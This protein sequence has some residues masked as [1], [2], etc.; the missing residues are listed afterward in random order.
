[1][2]SPS[3][4]MVGHQIDSFASTSVFRP[5]GQHGC[6]ATMLCDARSAEG[7]RNT[8]GN[9]PLHGKAE[10]PVM[11]YQAFSI[12]SLGSPPVAGTNQTSAVPLSPEAWW[13]MISDPGGTEV[14]EKLGHRS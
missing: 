13:K 11:G 4:D 7:W 3:G 10:A 14:S 5:A 2:L 8:M 9:S 6:P 1:M 12:E